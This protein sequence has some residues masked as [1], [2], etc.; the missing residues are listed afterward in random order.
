MDVNDIRGNRV[1]I[2][3]ALLWGVSMVSCRKAGDSI[4]VEVANESKEA[5]L[6]K[7]VELSLAD[8]HKKCTDGSRSFRV[9]DAT[10]KEIPSQQTYDSLLIF[11]VSLPA[12]QTARYRIEPCDLPLDYPSKVGGRIY[13]E[14]DDD[15]A[16]EN[17][18]VGFRAY[19]PAL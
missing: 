8:L 5:V 19:G 2:L 7:M 13:P 1:W 18:R 4:T 3:I 14:R 17:E 11:Q 15:V 12:G 6:D 10:G 9:L 16:W